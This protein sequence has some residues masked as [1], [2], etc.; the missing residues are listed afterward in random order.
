[1]QEERD[2]MRGL[3][4]IENVR[5][6]LLVDKNESIFALLAELYEKF[7][8]SITPLKNHLKADLLLKI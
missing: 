6:K 8:D 1:M 5:L 3:D 2:L 4:H 7:L